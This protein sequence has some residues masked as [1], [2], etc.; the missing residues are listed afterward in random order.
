VQEIV[1]RQVPEHDEDRIGPILAVL[2]GLRPFRRA[3]R[4]QPSN[5]TLAVEDETVKARVE[6]HP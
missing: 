4:L 3:E 2:G 1:K 6:I 5:Q